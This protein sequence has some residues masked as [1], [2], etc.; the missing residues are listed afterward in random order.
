MGRVLN[1]RTNSV[2]I[3][4]IIAVHG[5]VVEVIHDQLDG[6]GVAAATN[7]VRFFMDRFNGSELI[8]SYWIAL[9]LWPF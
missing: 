2:M 8:P 5:T 3:R 1:E 9:I 6:C 4:I 7:L